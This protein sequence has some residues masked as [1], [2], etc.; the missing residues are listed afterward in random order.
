[1]A[2]PEKASDVSAPALK[3]P[4]KAPQEAAANKEPKAP[5]GFKILKVRKP[6][7]T[8]IRV[9]RPIEP[10]QNPAEKKSAESNAGAATNGSTEVITTPA[11][12][13]E[14]KP[15]SEKHA[16]SASAPTDTQKSTP[17]QQH[18]SSQNPASAAQQ[19]APA[20]TAVQPRQR[21]SRP[22]F[23]A[24]AA[25]A[26]TAMIPSI[27]DIGDLHEGDEILDE[28]NDSEGFD[29]GDDYDNGGHDGHDDHDTHHG[30][31]N[32]GHQQL[33]NNVA[34]AGATGLAAG[35]SA[36]QHQPPAYATA[37]NGA[38]QNRAAQSQTKSE[39]QVSAK[40][41]LE[42]TE[43][44]I[45]DDVKP[46]DPGTRSLHKSFSDW[47]RYII[48][49]IMISFPILYIGKRLLCCTQ[50]CT[51]D[52]IQVLGILTA[53]LPTKDYN[54]AYGTGLAQAIKVAV[55]AWPIIFA[56]IAAQSLRTIA[57]YKVERGVRLMVST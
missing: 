50:E 19:A 30:G 4:V 20:A 24:F 55:S 23:S 54:G 11:K 14:A 13:D 57:A 28:D 39:V 9:K 29:D 40:P 44:G 17:T 47:T 33:D 36:Q 21:S 7:G 51:A 45:D 3:D 53:I 38:A 18:P 48:W 31:A 27:G 16:T 52:F 46:G 49:F 5:P 6:D 25:R 35:L 42:V 2:D 15:A 26:V 37:Q 10:T 56:A 43:K 32:G 34:M 8:I 41:Q 12:K 22:F 1:M